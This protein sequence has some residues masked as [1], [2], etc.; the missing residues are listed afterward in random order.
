MGKRL[1]M[2]IFYTC[3]EQIKD[4]STIHKWLKI[5]KDLNIIHKWLKV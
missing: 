1:K 3:G 2:Q 5:K 4:I